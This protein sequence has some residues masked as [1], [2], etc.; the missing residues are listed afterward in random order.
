VRQCLDLYLRVCVCCLC[1][2]L[3]NAKG[4]ISLSELR[5][6]HNALITVE[7]K[8][9][10]GRLGKKVGGGGWKVAAPHGCELY[11]QSQPFTLQDV[12][13]AMDEG[14]RRETLVDI[15]VIDMASDT[16]VQGHL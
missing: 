9:D 11:P 1:V 4:P 3:P 14:K 13:L 6:T 10:P 5:I 12:P 15:S 2:Q 8:Q 7:H 16:V